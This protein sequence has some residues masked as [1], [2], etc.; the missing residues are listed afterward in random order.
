MA[1]HFVYKRRDLEVTDERSKRAVAVTRMCECWGN[2]VSR[3]FVR[4]WRS[5]GLETSVEGSWWEN[6]YVPCLA[7]VIVG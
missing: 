4:E 1:K 7:P 6:V 2:Q 5:N 3:V